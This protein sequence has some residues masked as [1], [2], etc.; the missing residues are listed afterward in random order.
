MFALTPGA[1]VIRGL[2]YFLVPQMVSTALRKSSGSMENDAYFQEVLT[3]NAFAQATQEQ[4]VAADTLLIKMT[5]YLR[6]DSLRSP[7][8]M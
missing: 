2:G 8:V 7:L 6:A 1:I 5:D 4:F 3:H